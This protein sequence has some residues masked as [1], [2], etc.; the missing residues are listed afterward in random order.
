MIVKSPARW[1]LVDSVDISAIAKPREA[2]I[3]TGIIG[4]QVGQNN[5]LPQNPVVQIIMFSIFLHFQ[6]PIFC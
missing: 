3:L 2:T 5:R 4:S 1:C 6:T